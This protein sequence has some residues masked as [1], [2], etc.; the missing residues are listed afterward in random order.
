MLQDVDF[1]VQPGESVA[2]VGATGSGKTTIISLLR[3]STTCSAAA[4]CRRR[5]RARPRSGDAAPLFALV[6]QDVHLF[7]GTIGRQ[8]PAGARDLDERRA[9]AAGPCTPTGFIERLPGGYDAAVAER[10][11]TLS[12]GQKQLLSFARALALDR[13]VL[14]LDEAT[15]TVD[16]ETER[17]IQALEVLLQGRTTIVIAHRLSTIQNMDRSWCCTRAR[18]RA[19]TH[20]ALLAAARHLLPAVPAAVSAKGGVRRIATNRAWA[21]GISYAVSEQDAPRCTSP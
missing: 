17:T 11:A 9:R 8:H 6:L 10:G 18:P 2:L 14:I 7:S 5:R 3:A 12:V 16:T 13:R 1:E 19:G 20:Q 15:S 21:H 4:S